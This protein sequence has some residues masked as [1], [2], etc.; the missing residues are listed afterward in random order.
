VLSCDAVLATR[1][2]KWKM[3]RRASCAR[4][5]LVLLATCAVLLPTLGYSNEAVQR[6]VVEQGSV[7][8]LSCEDQFGLY[9]MHGGGSL[10]RASY[11]DDGDDSMPGLLTVKLHGLLGNLMFAVAAL[12]GV[13]DQLQR[14]P[15]LSLVAG[16][17]PSDGA[18][19]DA[20]YDL[21]VKRIKA[22]A[23]AFGFLLCENHGNSSEW[24]DVPFT[25]GWGRY[26]VSIM[27]AQCDRGN[28]TGSNVADDGRGQESPST[29]RSSH[30][31]SDAAGGRKRGYLQ[32]QKNVR[33]TVPFSRHYFEHLGRE[34]MRRLF[35]FPTQV[36]S[37]RMP[38][39]MR[40]FMRAWAV[41]K[42]RQSCAG[43][44]LSQAA[45]EALANTV[46]KRLV[47]RSRKGRKSSWTRHA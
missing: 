5:L 43:R 4:I 31:G 38:K 28:T 16:I 37:P 10:A 1:R 21:S 47:C 9:S 46:L 29:T 41:M 45:K 32:S 34:R 7:L 26:D 33:M 42:R 2:L 6:Q 40:V 23:S 27:P 36:G 12:E 20:A 13:A 24:L 15:H 35:R 22:F 3:V 14:P 39:R 19:D 25:R 11:A 8:K 30:C 44:V 18:R 17:G